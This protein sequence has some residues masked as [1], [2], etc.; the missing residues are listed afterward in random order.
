MPRVFTKGSTQYLHS[1]TT[2][3]GGITG[4]PWSLSLLVMFTDI[5]GA[6]QVFWFHGDSSADND[7]AWMLL[8]LVATGVIRF[9]T[10][11]TAADENTDTVATVSADTWY[12]VGVVCASATSR[13][14]YLAAVE[15]AEGTTDLTPAGVDRW[16]CGARF[17]SSG[18]DLACSCR[19]LWPG[20]WNDGLSANDMLRLAEPREPV[21]VRRDA[22]QFFPPLVDGN[23]VDIIGGL[24][25]TAVNTPTVVD[26]WP[27][28]VVRAMPR[29]RGR[30]RGRAIAA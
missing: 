16:A 13:K 15:E 8:L 23:D 4:Y 3:P 20:M 12:H 25:L 17:D 22:L 27:A 19:V 24:A 6:D 9:Q 26:D 11:T 29:A 30:G 5:S 1:G 14:L 7:E 18:A 28:A 21:F 10:L 2:A